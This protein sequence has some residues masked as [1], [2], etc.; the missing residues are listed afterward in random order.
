MEDI[1]NRLK[2]TKRDDG[3]IISTISS[4]D[5]WY[6]P[7]ETAIRTE[8]SNWKVA[9]GYENAE[10]ALKGHEKYC[11]MSEEYIN[12]IKYVEDTVW[13]YSEHSEFN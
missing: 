5:N 2:Y 4:F 6:G 10:D 1:Q 11:A 3:Y 7:Y 8:G 9:E 13:K 12:K